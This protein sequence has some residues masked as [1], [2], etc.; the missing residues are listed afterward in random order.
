MRPN[1]CA[2]RLS[3]P[4]WCLQLNILF[5]FRT[6]QT[7]SWIYIK[8]VIVAMLQVTRRKKINWRVN[9]L[10]ASCAI[11]PCLNP[12]LALQWRRLTVHDEFADSIDIVLEVLSRADDRRVFPDL[13][14]PLRRHRLQG[15]PHHRVVVPPPARSPW[16]P[17]AGEGAAGD[18]VVVQHGVELVDGEWEEAAVGL[19][20]DTGR[21]LRVRQQTDLC[22]Q[23][24]TEYTIYNFSE[25]AVHSTCVWALAQWSRPG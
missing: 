17:G 5:L 23:F 16:T 10:E 13:V 3:Q 14:Q 7:Y 8:L 19:G 25:G 20:P 9:K 6:M 1:S 2:S 4:S 15:P 12:V 22:T 18:R 21:P 24:A 11:K